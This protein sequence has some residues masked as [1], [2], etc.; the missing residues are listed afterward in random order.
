MNSE[1]KIIRVNSNGVNN[2]ETWASFP[3][4][5]KLSTPWDVTSE[6]QFTLL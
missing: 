5:Q 2:E 4:L 6:P 3:V 1:I